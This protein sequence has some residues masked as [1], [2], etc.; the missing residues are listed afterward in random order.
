MLKKILTSEEWQSL[1]IL[2]L[3]ILI[4]I[5]QTELAKIINKF[6]LSDFGLF[7]PFTKVSDSEKQKG[8]IILKNITYALKFI[9]L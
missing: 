1:Q 3:I 8:F 5:N 6:F 4:I 9:T 7:I 2:L